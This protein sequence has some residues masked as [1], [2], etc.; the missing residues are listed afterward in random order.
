MSQ[1]CA[2]RSQNAWQLSAKAENHLGTQKV[3]TKYRCPIVWYVRASL[4][5]IER[6]EANYTLEIRVKLCMGLN[7]SHMSCLAIL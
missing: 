5:E 3:I 2:E 7:V 4:W 1:R 6:G